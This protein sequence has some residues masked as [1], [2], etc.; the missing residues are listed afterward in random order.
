MREKE[1]SGGKSSCLVAYLTAVSGVPWC[2]ASVFR[3]RI[4]ARFNR[5]V[6]SCIGYCVAVCLIASCACLMYLA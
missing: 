1:T 2:D 6:M 5:S 3:I 4:F